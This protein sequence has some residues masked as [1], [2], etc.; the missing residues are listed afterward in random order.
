MPSWSL[1]QVSSLFTMFSHKTVG[2]RSRG[3]LRVFPHPLPKEKVSELTC[4][5]QDGPVNFPVSELNVCISFPRGFEGFLRSPAWNSPIYG[6]KADERERK[7]M[8][9]LETNL[10]DFFFHWL[11]QNKQELFTFRF[12]WCVF[13]SLNE[14]LVRSYCT[15]AFWQPLIKEPYVT[16]LQGLKIL[17][18]TGPTNWKVLVER[19]LNDLNTR[20]DQL[21]LQD[22]LTE[23]SAF[24]VCLVSLV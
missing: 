13:F 5:D 10:W 23:G 11:H 16:F 9:D 6:V 22:F 3:P 17:V 2:I 12:K 15:Y 4:L 18:Y 19:W 7:A 14:I 24:F 21:E 8:Q 20:N 1:K